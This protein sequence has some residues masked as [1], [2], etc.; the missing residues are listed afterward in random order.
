MWHYTSKPWNDL[1]NFTWRR[2]NV[3]S[4]VNNFKNNNFEPKSRIRLFSLRLSISFYIGSKHAPLNRSGDHGWFWQWVDRGWEDGKTLLRGQGS[5][6]SWRHLSCMFTYVCSLLID[7]DLYESWKVSI[8]FPCALLVYFCLSL[9]DLLI[10]L[11]EVTPFY[12]NFLICILQYFFS[13]SIYIQLQ[14]FPVFWLLINVLSGI[15]QRAG[16]PKAVFCIIHVIDNVV[17]SGK[18]WW[19]R[20][21]A[22]MREGKSAFKMLT[23]KLTGYRSLGSCRDFW[24]PLCMQH[25]TIINSLVS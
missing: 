4:K 12:S 11:L 7:E 1:I 2:K 19:I 5:R 20:H 9:G 14:T 16:W 3:S 17:K 21:V 6:V 24:W 13:W 8:K 23:G 18:L 15:S 10:F 25:W 22:R